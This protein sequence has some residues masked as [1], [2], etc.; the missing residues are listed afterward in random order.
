LE[1]LSDL[2]HPNWSQAEILAANRGPLHPLAIQ[3]IH[4]FNRGDFFAAHEYLEIAWR[5]EAGPLREVYRG[6]LQ[7]G[8]AYYHILRGNYP[9]AVKMFQ[10]SKPWLA[11]FPACYRGIDVSRLRIDS[12]LVET[13]LLQLG[14]EKFKALNPALMKPVVLQNL[15]F[16]DD[17]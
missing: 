16:E 1:S 13:E 9:G 8:L 7:V 14:P 10:R 12:S 3:G 5:E 2:P 17:H 4:A 6:I 15:P 11:P